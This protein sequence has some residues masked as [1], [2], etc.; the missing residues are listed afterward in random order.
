[1]LGYERWCIT[2]MYY[3]SY[4]YENAL[5]VKPTATGEVM[6]DLGGWVWAEAVALRRDGKIVVAGVNR[7]STQYLQPETRNL[8]PEPLVSGFR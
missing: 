4:F 1:M 6:T 5:F 3:F 2:Q 7:L 8:M